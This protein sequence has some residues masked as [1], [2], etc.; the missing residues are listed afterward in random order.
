M[1]GTSALILEQA[2]QHKEFVK[3]IRDTFKLSDTACTKCGK[4]HG[5]NTFF[6]DLKTLEERELECVRTPEGS[7]NRCQSEDLLLMPDDSVRAPHQ[8]W[9]C[10]ML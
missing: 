8:R 6:E 2:A 3:K 1:A 4:E 10:L 5:W 9:S 7:G